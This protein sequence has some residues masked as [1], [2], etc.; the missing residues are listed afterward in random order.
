MLF[1]ETGCIRD[2]E[3]VNHCGELEEFSEEVT[4]RCLYDEDDNL[5][6]GELI[7]CTNDLVECCD[8]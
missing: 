4:D 1:V 8:P 2:S 3:D 6:C 7:Q 5:H